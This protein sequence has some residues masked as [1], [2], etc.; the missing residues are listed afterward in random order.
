MVR[1]KYRVEIVDSNGSVQLWSKS[2]TLLKS[3]WELEEE[4]ESL[5]ELESTPLQGRIF[6]QC[7]WVPVEISSSEDQDWVYDKKSL[8]S[9]RIQVIVGYVPELIRSLSLSRTQRLLLFKESLPLPRWGKVD[10]STWIEVL[11][12]LLLQPILNKFTKATVIVIQE[13]SYLVWSMQADPEFVQTELEEGDLE[14]WITRQEDSVR[15]S[16]L[17]LLGSRKQCVEIVPDRKVWPGPVME[18][19]QLGKV[20]SDGKCWQQ[21]LLDSLEK[22]EEYEFHGHLNS[23]MVFKSLVITSILGFFLFLA[24]PPSNQDLLITSNESLSQEQA[25]RSQNPDP[26]QVD[27]RSYLEMG[28]M[29]RA[30]ESNLKALQDLAS[31]PQK[32]QS[33]LNSKQEKSKEISLRSPE[34]SK[35]TPESMKILSYKAPGWSEYM[36]VLSVGKRNRCAQISFLSQAIELCK[37]EKFGGFVLSEL[38]S[39]GIHFESQENTFSLEVQKVTDS[40]KLSRMDQNKPSSLDRSASEWISHFKASR[41]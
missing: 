22:S 17:I 13:N 12:A 26:G 38:E 25:T 15:R 4:R 36:T 14:N 7:K 27:Q 21:V 6:V 40:G 33:P 10:S 29:V 23:R 39:A 8:L 3:D 20:K 11:P 41:I 31:L 2:K 30:I 32:S 19:A 34:S 1:R 35:S 9:D 5:A 24:T 16:P 37:G 18:Y 28:T